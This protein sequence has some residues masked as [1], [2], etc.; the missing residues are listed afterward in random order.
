MVCILVEPIQSTFGDMYFPDSFFNGLRNLAD[1]YDIPLIFDEIQVGFGTTGKLWFYEH[2][3]IEPDILVYGKKTQVSG[4][5][6]KEKFAKIFE[7]SV[8]LEVTWD[9]NIMDMVTCKYI[10]RAY[11]EYDVLRNVQLMNNKLKNGLM[12]MRNIMNLRECGLL[13]AFD[14]NSKEKRDKFVRCLYDN[15][16]ICNPTRDFTVRLRP[17]LCLTSKEV[18]HALEIFKKADDLL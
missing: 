2:I 10:I 4:I 15:G 12:K 13:F 16:M 14:F 7:N 1:E 5:M 8:R 6:V 11:Q 17:N 3:D 9:G 18:D